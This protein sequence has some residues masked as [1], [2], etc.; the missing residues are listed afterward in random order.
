MT[1]PWTPKPGRLACVIVGCRRTA[2]VAKFGPD[3]IIICGKCSRLAPAERKE[4]R[5]WRKLVGKA[6]ERGLTSISLP[7]IYAKM[8]AA[9]DRLVARVTEIKMGISA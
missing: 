9:W 3:S 4:F 1:E 6:Q 8:D 2:D 7:R 5:R